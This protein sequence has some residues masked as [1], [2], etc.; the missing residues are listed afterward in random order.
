MKGQNAE[1]VRTA[2]DAFARRDLDRLVDCLADDITWH[3]PGVGML[4][5]D[6]QGRA[7]VRDYLERA[8][9]L[10]EGTLHVRPVDFLVGQDHVAA[11]VDISGTRSG[12]TLA[13]RAV[14]LF[15]LRDGRITERR[16]YPA[17]QKAFDTFWEA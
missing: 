3:T 8:V 14:Q 12:R 10:T 7:A 13:D 2:L 11:V 1:V 4:A 9:A 6:F 17:N 15:R 5:G 16:I